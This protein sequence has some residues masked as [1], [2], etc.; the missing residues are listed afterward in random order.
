MATPTSKETVFH[1]ADRIRQIESSFQP[2]APAPIPLG[3]SGLGG[4]FPAGARPAGSVID[5][6]S[7]LEGAG[8]WTLALVFAKFACG[9]HKVL[10]VADPQHCFS[11]PAAL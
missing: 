5:L 8:A 11:P 7:S 10:L 1:L 9:E 4:L 6:V 2:S 3:S